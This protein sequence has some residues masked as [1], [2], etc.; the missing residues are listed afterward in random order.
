M[1]FYISKYISKHALHHRTIRGFP[2]VGLEPNLERNLSMLSG[3][4]WAGGGEVLQAPGT[5]GAKAHRTASTC[6][7]AAVQGA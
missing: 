4:G 1:L 3:Q 7:Q 5:A 2:E 6:L